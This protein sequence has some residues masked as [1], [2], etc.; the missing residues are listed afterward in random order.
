MIAHRILHVTE[1]FGGGVASAI[2]NF[3]RNTPQYEHHLAL[4]VD[5]TC[6]SKNLVFNNI[7]QIFHLP[8]GHLKRIGFIKKIVYSSNYDLIHAHSS[9]A[10]AYVRTALSP[11]QIP[12]VYAPHCFAFERLDISATLRMVYRA[13]ETVFARRTT[14]I[15]ACSPR[16]VELARK[17]G[18]TI[19]VKYIPNIAASLPE[20]LNNWVWQNP[21]ASSNVTLAMVGRLSSQK[22]PDFF[23]ATVLCL[24]DL[25]INVTPIWFGGGDEYKARVL[26]NAEIEVTG[27]LSTDVLLKKLAQTN[28]IYL[29]SALWEGMP[30]SILEAV[31]LG[32]PL[33][34]RNI[35]AFRFLGIP[36]RLLI[37]TP[38]D[39]AFAIHS[40]LRDGYESAEQLRS[41]FAF[42]NDVEQSK[43]LQDLYDD[44][45]V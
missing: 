19:N 30:L 31:K 7:S 33:I 2:L 42:N 9:I 27:W 38:S 10:G 34:V 36:E 15:A 16:E 25:G 3:I 43:A 18:R 21:T 14:V 12:I 17:L 37:D 35:P 26:R 39:A 20:C 28:A 8:K 45:F 11:K 22:D 44:I 24:R 4:V 29:H 13:I 1:A 41:V 23:L 40:L 5:P 32:C 6:L